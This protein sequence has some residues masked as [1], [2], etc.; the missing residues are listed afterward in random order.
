MASIGRVK[1]NVLSKN[2]FK[3][4]PIFT[5][6]NE[7]VR[8]FYQKIAERTGGCLIPISEMHLMTGILVAIAM[9]ETGNLTAYIS[10]R[11]Y[12]GRITQKKRMYFCFC[13]EVLVFF[14]SFSIF[15]FW[16]WISII[17]AITSCC[18][19]TYRLLSGKM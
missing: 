16:I 11:E 18:S 3:V 15:F 12:T 4:Y 5:G 2:E 10:H 19:L 17:H 1:W 9:K 6:D 7:G 14:F 13:D 8:D